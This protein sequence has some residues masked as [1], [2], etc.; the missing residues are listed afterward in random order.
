[1]ETKENLK[2]KLKSKKSLRVVLSVVAIIVTTF[3]A[4][5]LANVSTI[6]NQIGNPEPQTDQERVVELG[7]AQVA[8][9]NTF[10]VALKTDGSVWTWGN[11]QY[12]QLGNG[13]IENVSSSEPAHVLGVNG[14]GYLENIKQISAGTNT[15]SALT[16]D[17][18]VVSWGLNGSG[19]IGN[20]TYTNTGMPV[21]AQKQVEVTDAEG[22]TSIKYEDLDHIVQISQGS[23]HALALAEDGTVWSWGSNAVGQLGINVTAY[24]NYAVKVQQ[25]ITVSE[26]TDEAGNQITKDVE[27]LLDLGNIKQV[28]AGENFSSALTNEGTVLNWGIGNLGQIGNDSTSNVYV[29]TEV[30]ELTNVKKVEAGGYQTVALKEDGTVWAWGYNNNSNLGCGVYS[31]FS[32]RP[33][34]VLLDASN[35]ITDVVDITSNY[36]TSFALKND[37]TVYGWGRNDVGQIGDYTSSP[38]NFATQV[39]INAG[40]GITNIAKLQDGQNTNTNLMIDQSGKIY[41]NGVASSYQFMNDRTANTMFA[42]PLDE[43]YLRINQNQDYLEVGNDLTLDVDY[44]NGF[45]IANDTLKVGNISY[46]SS[47]E[48]IATVSASGKVTAK[49]RGKVTII[50]ED[51]SNGMKAQA[52]INVVS[53]GATALPQVVTGTTFTAYLKEDGTVW[54]SGA[55]AYGELGNGSNIAVNVPTQVKINTNEYLTDIKKIAVGVQHAIA[56][57]KDGTVWAWGYNGM[58]QLG[59]GTNNAKYAIQ[60]ENITGDGYL[61]NI[62][63]IDAGLYK[64]SALSKDGK[65][66]AWGDASSDGLGINST[67]AQRRPV[68]VHG[69]SNGIQVQSGS[70]NVM[71]LKGDGSVWGAGQNNLGQLADNTQTQRAEAVPSINSTKDGMLTDVVRIATGNHHTIALKRDK[72]AWIWGYNSNGQ[73]G[74]NSTTNQLAPIALKGLDNTGIMEDITDIATGPEASY[75][76]LSNG[77]VYAVGLNTTGELS[78]G[79]TTTVKVFTQVK[80]E[81]SEAITGVATINKSMGASFGFAFEDGTV[82]VTGLGTSGQHGDNTW[83]TTNQMTRIEDASMSTGDL[84]EVPVNG[85]AKIKVTAEHKFNLNINNTLEIKGQ[86]LTYES[87]NEEIATVSSDGTIKGIAKGNT[88]IKVIDEENGIEA[89]AQ[90][91]V[92]RD[93]SAIYKVVSGDSHT[94]LLKQDGTV[95]AWGDNTYGQLGN[96]T[97]SGKETSNP[98]QVLGVKGEGY[99]T[100]VVDIAAGEYFTIALKRN[101]EIVAWG[102]NN[103]GQLGDA[104][105]SA[106]NPIRVKDKYGNYLTGI[107]DLSA[108]SDHAAAVKADGTVWTWG[109]NGY[110]Q[111]GDQ[112]WNNSSFAIPVSDLD[113]IKQVSVGSGFVATLA[114]DGTV[115]SW[116]N[117]A[118]GQLGNGAYST[119]NVP[120]QA[121]GVSDVT[122]IVT[123]YYTTLVL[124]EDGTVWA[125]GNNGYGQLGDSSFSNKATAMQVKIDGST[126]LTDVVDIGANAYTNY[127]ITSEGTVYGWGQGALGQ[128][129]NNE[130][131]NKNLATKMTRR[132]GSELGDKVVRLS[133]D[134]TN[135][136]TN[137]M[138]TEDGSLVGSG[139]SNNGQM[140]NG[141]TSYSSVNY[142]HDVLPSYL[143]ITDTISY[144]K[145]GETKKL[146]VKLCEEIGRVSSIGN[147]TFA[148]TNE[149][150][151]IV[152]KDGTI[153]AKGLGETTIIVKEDKYGYRA[154]ATIYVTENRENLI[155]SPMIVQGTSFTGILKADGTVWTTGLN[156]NGQLGDGTNTYRADLQPVK[157]DANTNL[158]NIVRIAAG[159]SHML[160]VTKDGQVYSWGLG[161]YGQLGNNT[162]ANSNYAQKVLSED[163]ESALKSIIDVSAGE[164]HSVAMD[165]EGNVYAWGEAGYYQLG[166]YNAT[167]QKL[168][169]KMRD[170]YNVVKVTAG[171]KYTMLLRGDGIVEGTG[172]GSSYQLAQGDTATYYTPKECGSSAEKVIYDEI[173]DIVAGGT[174][175]Y[176]L[177]EDGLAYT[178]GS[179]AYGQTSQAGIVNATVLTKLQISQGEGANLVPIENVVNIYAGNA[180]VFAVTKEGKVY[181]AGLNTSGQLGLGGTTSPVNV[182]TTVKDENNEKDL[183]KVLFVAEGSSNTVNSGYILSDGTVWA[184][185]NGEFGQLGNETY[186]DHVNVIKMSVDEIKAKEQQVKLSINQ[187]NQIELSMEHAFNAYDIQKD[188]SSN[189]KYEA[190]NTEV[191]TVSDTGVITGKRLGNTKIKITDIDNNLEE[192]VFVNVS[193]SLGK[194][195]AKV[196]SGQNFTIAL[197]EDGTVWSWGHGESGQLG[198]GNTNN[199]TEA[200]QVLAPDGIKKLTN[201]KDIAVGYS[202]AAALLEDGTIVA[203]GNNNN[204]NLGDGTN[205]NRSVPVYVVDANKE[206]LQGIV[207][208]VKGSDFNLALTERGEIYSWGYNGNGQLGLNHTATTL[209]PSKVKDETSKGVL[210]N[211][212]DITCGSSTSYALTEDGQIWSWGNNGNGQFGNGTTGWKSVPQKAEINNVAKVIASYD[213]AIALKEDGSVWSW[214][215]NGYGTTGN[216]TTVNNVTTPVQPEWEDGTIITKAIDIGTSEYTHYILDAN[217]KVYAAGYNYQGLIGDTTKNTSSCYTEVKAKY[218]DTITNKIVK[219]SNSMTRDANT[220]FI[221]EDGSILGLG[222]NINNQLFGNMTDN[223][224]SAKEMN[225]SYMEITDRANYI[226]I[227]DTKKLT[228][229]VV[230]N[231]NMYAKEPVT[232]EVTWSSS[233]AKIATV[234]N[235]GNVTAKE[236][237]QT[238]ITAV[239][240]KYG[241]VASATIYVT[242]NTENTITI[243]QVAQGLNFTIVLKA[244]GTVWATGANDVGQCGTGSTD[245]MMAELTQVKLNATTPL[246]NVVK[247][248]SGSSHTIA[249]T[250]DGK[251]YAWGLN[252][253]GQ[254]GNNTTTNSKYAI[255][256]LNQYGIEGVAD[257]IDIAAGKQHSIV[258]SKNGEVY[259]AGYNGMGQLGDY[260]FINRVL[261][262]KLQEMQNVIQVSAGE[263]HT[264]LL[265]GDGTVWTVGA[266]NNGQFG[267][268]TTTGNS[269][270]VRQAIN[271]NDNGVMKNITRNSIRIIA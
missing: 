212:I 33:V 263:N 186:F 42:V 116:G 182:L 143:R 35:P 106:E 64:S 141:T 1:M 19:Q 44:Y 190:L 245:Q 39:K 178:V 181:S 159:S 89:I 155:T 169:I 179:G 53:K 20:N 160:A 131:N 174:T 259:G 209:V 258:L 254:L 26:T 240:S 230:E 161:S 18:K 163:G 137:Y 136:C 134:S 248:A 138:I 145:K 74:I 102:R 191:A 249:L 239:D 3:V 27:K 246:T 111:L 253:S 25:L 104:N 220:Y 261:L 226:K 122:K 187:T 268:N 213:S 84:Y 207:K 57:K 219:I 149:N 256:M 267:N 198:T 171:T 170:V 31:S 183:E 77:T 99:L 5:G 87:L 157:I 214:G 92:D 28:S 133:S 223:L 107:V 130:T 144:L 132:W 120:V 118:Y 30:A 50:A 95:W 167:N 8:S 109:A 235:S 16:A 72:T 257:I 9:G 73:Q 55:T 152:G 29:P 265:R 70:N 36:E 61:E 38:K 66:Y 82:G 227:G 60:V 224:Y 45:N 119:K 41:G 62:V 94:V 96:G 21:Y 270:V 2:N 156:T 63:D 79:T 126:Y 215:Y 216:G 83:T 49:A 105:D 243:P 217:Y 231:F 166:N 184:T 196:M 110:G 241:Y 262:V 11:N 208:I 47:N 177:K 125:W 206:K 40:E 244:D 58:G 23:D 205:T 37:G 128:I 210:S 180:T 188:L 242:R 192:Y 68:L 76:K 52:I 17:G 234:D 222:E 97:F 117:G 123:T 7:N 232:G 43:T 51:T 146:E 211:I 199:Q 271:E 103:F 32:S 201:V 67:S 54:T 34:Q 46:Q 71:V 175:T 6:I 255:E 237:G 121:T 172:Y 15:V 185:G 193:E 140:L 164:N 264:M 100:D 124:K 269:W 135:S 56:L 238:T 59:N 69:I 22:V 142:V 228:T 252:S 13:K 91:V 86:N 88:G 203:W 162:T 113:N 202:S 65:V 139:R 24:K 173:Y 115:W 48:E 108:T 266:N 247:I 260:T 148:S 165:N 200:V 168:P 101:G 218:G 250:K 93:L 129:G 75:V 189:I 80:D 4:T 14:E 197:K 127:A 225:A 176:F 151:A 158:T 112:T 90:V 114:N 153:T 10:S 195:E 204:Y 229:N 194:T 81:N 85:T 251:V 221:R 236:E 233:N 12:G 98:S 78:V 147:L 154:Q 150:V